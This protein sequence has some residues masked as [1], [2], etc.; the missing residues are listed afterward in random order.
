MTKEN[1][2]KRTNV[3]HKEE[4]VSNQTIPTETKMK[5]KLRLSYTAKIITHVLFLAVFAISFF[6][7]LFLAISITKNEVV[8]YREKY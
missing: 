1:S 5:R 7:F 6:L 4:C 3:I 2:T 8:R